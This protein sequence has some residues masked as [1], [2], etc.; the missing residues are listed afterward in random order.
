MDAAAHCLDLVADLLHVGPPLLA[1]V[2]GEPVL[3]GEVEAEAGVGGQDVLR[4]IDDG[5]VAG[6]VEV[7]L[8]HVSTAERSLDFRVGDRLG[9]VRI[10]ALLGELH[11]GLEGR[12]VTIDV[13]C[14]FYSL[15]LRQTLLS[16]I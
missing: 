14:H 1:A 4:A 5:V 3:A 7:G 11:E 16:A 15:V 8:D 13:E 12:I 2:R 9:V 10:H 6:A